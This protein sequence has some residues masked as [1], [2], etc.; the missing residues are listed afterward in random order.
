M[1][2]SDPVRGREI[3][4]NEAK[5]L[6]CHTVDGLEQPDGQQLD[7]GIAVAPGPDL[8]DIA[9]FNSIGLIEESTLKPNAQITK[10]YGLATVKTDGDV[11]Q[12]T[13]ISR[14]S[15]KVVLRIVEEN[16]NEAERNRSTGRS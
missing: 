10:G 12:G 1:L 3:F 9:A 13:L 2:E 14:D 6:A 5:C 4:V 8:T 16:G 15:E 7:D 11:I